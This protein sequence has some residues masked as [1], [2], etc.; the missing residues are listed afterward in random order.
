MN[1]NIHFQMKLY[2]VVNL[3]SQFFEKLILKSH[4][5][6]KFQNYSIGTPYLFQT[7]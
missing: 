3:K 2:F 5:Q 1:S 7:K 4:Q 6:K